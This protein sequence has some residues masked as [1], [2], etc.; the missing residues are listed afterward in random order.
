MVQTRCPELLELVINDPCFELTDPILAAMLYDPM[1]KECLLVIGRRD[2]DWLD[3]FGKRNTQKLIDEVK[4][5]ILSSQR[6][7]SARK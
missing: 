1:G 7:K 2:F 3:K 6:Q 5:E 4:E